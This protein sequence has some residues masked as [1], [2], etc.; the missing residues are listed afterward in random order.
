MKG[1]VAYIEDTEN[2]GIKLVFDDVHS[3]DAKN[4][5][6]WDHEVF[7]TSNN[8]DQ[9]KLKGMELSKEQYAEIGENIIIRLLALNR[10]RSYSHHTPLKK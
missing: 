3:N 1:V 6:K 8:Y 5:K 9:E 4:P 10:G 7:F 2:G